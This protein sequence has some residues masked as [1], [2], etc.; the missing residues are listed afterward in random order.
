LSRAL[1]AERLRDAVARH[2]LLIDR[3]S[4]RMTVSLGVAAL[5]G[6]ALG[7]DELASLADRALYRA[8]ANGRDRVE[9]AD[10][11]GLATM[12]PTGTT[13]LQIGMGA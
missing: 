4:L 12:H 6:H 10:Q 5:A 3:G 8:K 2:V 13:M 7:F 11:P 9:L 1:I